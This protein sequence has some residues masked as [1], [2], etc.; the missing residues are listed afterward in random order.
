M[1]AKGLQSAACTN[2]KVR[3][4]RRDEETFICS[5]IDNATAGSRMTHA[6]K[7]TEARMKPGGVNTPL[8]LLLLM[9]RDKGP[10]QG[11]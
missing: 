2:Y 9:K 11:V 3:T 10:D 8:G 6:Q 5:Y 7:S 1:S 4:W